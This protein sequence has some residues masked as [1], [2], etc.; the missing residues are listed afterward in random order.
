[1]RTLE[2][3]LHIRLSGAEYKINRSDTSF[4]HQGS[5]I[6]GTLAAAQDQAAFSR[7]VA[8]PRVWLCAPCDPQG[9]RRNEPAPSWLTS[10]NESFLTNQPS[11]LYSLSLPS[12]I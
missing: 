8:N 9:E 1:M 10:L 12:C 3:K 4:D 11:L 6:E 5:S 7:E 2:E